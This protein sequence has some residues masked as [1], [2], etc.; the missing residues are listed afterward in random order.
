MPRLPNFSIFAGVERLEMYAEEC[1]L[2]G[3]A[4]SGLLVYK[5]PW[6]V[7]SRSQ[8]VAQDLLE[9]LSAVRAANLQDT[10]TLCSLCAVSSVLLSHI[11][12]AHRAASQQSGKDEDQALEGLWAPESE[13]VS[14]FSLL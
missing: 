7:S 4:S 11:W 3:K 6:A 8:I 9:A 10:Q 13:I 1:L 5:Q 12:K 14:M 2:D